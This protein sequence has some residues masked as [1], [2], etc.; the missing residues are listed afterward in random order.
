M[1]EFQDVFV[2]EMGVTYYKHFSHSLSLH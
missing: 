1:F 2:P